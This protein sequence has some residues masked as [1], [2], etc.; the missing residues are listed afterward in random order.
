MNRVSGHPTPGFGG[1]VSAAYSLCLISSRLDKS[2]AGNEV[3]MQNRAVESAT[4]NERRFPTKRVR[5]L[6]PCQMVSTVPE[7]SFGAMASIRIKATVFAIRE[8]Q[9]HLLGPIRKRHQRYTPAKD[10]LILSVLTA[11]NS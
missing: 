4:F 10:L 11:H 8:G 1:L 6:S 9:R 5:C 7:I 3:P 2:N